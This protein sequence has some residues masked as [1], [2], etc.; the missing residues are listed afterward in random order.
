MEPISQ[1]IRMQ[2]HLGGMTAPDCARY[3]LPQ[4]LKAKLELSVFA[5]GAMKAIH[6]TSQGIPRIVNL[7]RQRLDPGEKKEE[8]TAE[9]K[10]IAVVLADIDR[11]RGN[12]T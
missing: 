10:H 3:I 6:A 1:R 8:N 12:S 11:Q 9:E 4:M 2:Y 7:V 5:E